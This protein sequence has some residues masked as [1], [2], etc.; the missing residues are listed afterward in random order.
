MIAS[1]LV[2]NGVKPVNFFVIFGKFCEMMTRVL[3]F[4]L[5]EQDY[6]FMLFWQRVFIYV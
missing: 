6:F 3:F 2:V 1:V 5:I 4:F